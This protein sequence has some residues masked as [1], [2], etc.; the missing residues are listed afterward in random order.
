VIVGLGIDIAEVD[1]VRTAI[2]R[3]GEAF[4]KRVFTPEEIDY[5]KR[6]RNRF[7]RYAGRFAAKEAAMKALEQAGETGC[8]G[9]IS[10]LCASGAASQRCSFAVRHGNLPTVSKSRVSP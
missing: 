7:E 1:R 3:H 10:R 5:C 8:A 9:W 4:L 6:H 2:E